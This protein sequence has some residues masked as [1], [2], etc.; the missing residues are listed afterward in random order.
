MARM[1]RA[2]VELL[3]PCSVTLKRLCLRFNTPARKPVAAPETCPQ[4]RRR[5]RQQQLLRLDQIAGRNAVA[6]TSTLS[7]MLLY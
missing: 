5:A 1:L 6:T 7:L 2:T 3:L 4:Y